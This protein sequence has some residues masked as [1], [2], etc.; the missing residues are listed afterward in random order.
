MKNEQ[1]RMK[2]ENMTMNDSASRFCRDVCKLFV[3]QMPSECKQRF[4]AARRKART[5]AGDK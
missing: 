4:L 1:S 5:F 3:S 2:N